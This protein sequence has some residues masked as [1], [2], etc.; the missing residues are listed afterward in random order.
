MIKIMK[1]IKIKDLSEISK[2]HVSIIEYPDGTKY[3]FFKGKLHR[4]NGPA[5]EYFNGNVEYWLHG[6]KLTKKFFKKE[7]AKLKKLV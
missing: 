2:N 7:V 3:W 4:E 5:V 1:T 6:I